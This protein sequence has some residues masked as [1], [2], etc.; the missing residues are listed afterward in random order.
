MPGLDPVFHE[1]L[2]LRLIATLGTENAD[3]TIHLTAV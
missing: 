1:L 2:Q 3:G